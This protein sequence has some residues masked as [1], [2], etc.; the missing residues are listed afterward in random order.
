MSKTHVK[1][2]LDGKLPI[3]YFCQVQF[4]LYVTE[5]ASWWFMSHYPGIKP[6]MVEVYRDEKWISKMEIELTLF[7]DQLEDMVRQL[8]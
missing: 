7:N 4:S 8:K 5:R 1:Y 3:D 6:F 2:L